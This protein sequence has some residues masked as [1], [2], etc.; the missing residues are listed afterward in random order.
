VSFSVISAAGLVSVNAANSKIKDGANDVYSA[1]YEF[2]PVNIASSTLFAVARSTNNTNASITNVGTSAA[3]VLSAA[4]AVQALPSVEVLQLPPSAST[5]PVA[6]GVVQLR[7]KASFPGT[8]TAGNRVEFYA[9]G[10][11]LGVA[12][13]NTNPATLSQFTH[14]FNWTTPTNTNS[15]QVSA[16]AVGVNFTN[17]T[18]TFFGSS[19]SANSTTVN[20]STNPPPTVSITMPATNGAV[21]GVGITN[22][23]TATATAATNAS[24]REVQFYLDGIYQSSVTNFPYTFN[25][26]PASAGFYKFA[27]VAIDSFGLQANSEVRT[28]NATNGSAPSV[29]LTPTACRRASPSTP[30]Q[31]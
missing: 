5:N 24:I 2:T 12:T 6:G 19:L 13:N 11:L 16:R 26:V 4:Q 20:L 22:Q 9:G 18:G 1:A 23:I 21:V 7:A 8:N 29:S 28:I 30:L 25:F 14:V 31:R 10:A 17:T 3:S 15:F 27:A